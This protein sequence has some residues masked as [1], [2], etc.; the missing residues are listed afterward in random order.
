MDAL[1]VSALRERLAGSGWLESTR[2]FGG[3]LRRSVTRRASRG[4]LLVGTEAYEPWHLA[5]H[6]DEEAARS[7]A[8]LLAPTLLRHSVPA[9]APAHLS[10]GLRLLSERPR[11]T[12]V[13]LV[14]PA[15]PDE[16]LLERVEDARRGG[17]T[18][19]ALDGDTGGPAAPVHQRLAVPGLAGEP[20]DL[21]QHLVSAAAGAPA[22]RTPRL[23][24]L[25]E[26]LTAPPALRW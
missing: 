13:L 22:A 26:L 15:A 2:E 7:G 23:A 5:A 16:V 10:H 8:A 9:G 20:F 12:T 6:L 21:V 1:R 3:E 17:A 18:V 11:G 19:L 24:R 14:A 4:L 25:A